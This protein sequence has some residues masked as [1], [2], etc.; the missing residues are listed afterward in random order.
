VLNELASVPRGQAF[1][2]FLREPFLIA[3]KAIYRF[4]HKSLSRAALSGSHAREF[5][6]LVRGELHFHGGASFLFSD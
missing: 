5:D 1:I 2:H 6:F 3:Q 4:L